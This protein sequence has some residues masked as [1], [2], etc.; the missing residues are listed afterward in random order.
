VEDG[1]D[2]EVEKSSEWFGINLV[3]DRLCPLLVLIDKLAG[4]F[5]DIRLLIKSPHGCDSATG[6]DIGSAGN[7]IQKFR[8]RFGRE[9]FQR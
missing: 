4:G 7:D 6:L 3:R 9:R 2:Q 8:L 5:K 1:I